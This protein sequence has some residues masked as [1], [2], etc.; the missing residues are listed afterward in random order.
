MYQTT[1]AD[2]EVFK[3][4]AY[5]KVIAQIKTVP[6]IHSFEDVKDIAGIGAKIKDKIKEITASEGIE[7]VEFI[8]ARPDLHPLLA[9]MVQAPIRTSA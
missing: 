9:R 8:E 7:K 6:A 3:A 4:K 2:G 1:K 5:A